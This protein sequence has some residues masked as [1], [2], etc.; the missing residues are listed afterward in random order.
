MMP[1]RIGVASL[2]PSRGEASEMR[3]SRSRSVPFLLGSVVCAAMLA[4]PGSGQRI[5]AQDRPCTLETEPNDQLAS[6]P[7][8]AGPLCV[9]GELPDGDQDLVVWEVRPVDTLV[10]WSFGVSGVPRT[11][12]SIHVFPVTSPPGVALDTGG[13]MMRIDS[14]A[15]DP[16][17]G[18][19]TDIALPAGRYVLGISRGFPVGSR[20]PTDLGYRVWVEPSVAPPPVFDPEP[21]DDA[22]TGG[23]VARAFALSGDLAGSDDHVRW[24]LSEADAG[25]QWRLDARVPPGGPL[26][27]TVSGPG[28]ELLADAAAMPDGRARISDLQLPAGTYD[29]RLSAG[30]IEG[31]PYL[32][33]AS[34]VH[35]PFADTEPNDVAARAVPLDPD[36]TSARGRLAD[37][38]DRDTFR[39]SVDATRAAAAQDVVLVATGGRSHQVCLGGVVSQCRS[40]TDEVRLSN[41]VLVPGELLIEVSGDVDPEAGYELTLRSAGAPGPGRE[42]EP[43]DDPASAA[44][45][46]PGVVLAGR[47]DA[48]DHDH[49]LAV[50]EGETL[51]WRLEADGAAIK[52]LDWIQRDGQPL[53][54]GDISADETHAVL[55]DLLLDPGRHWFAVRASEGDYALRLIPMGPPDPDGE[56]EPNDDTTRAQALAIDHPRTGR[57][58][59]RRD[60]DVYRFSLAAREHV[61]MEL[62]PPQDGGVA[63]ELRSD[64]TTLV[65][66]TDTEPGVPVRHDLWL[67]AGDYEVWLRPDPVSES[68]HTLSLT[69]QDPF[70]PVA[71][72]P[73]PIAPIALSLSTDTPEV[74]AY[75]P[76]GQHVV[77]SLDI[78]DPGRSPAASPVSLTL[79]AL[80]SHHAWAATLDP[81]I[82]EVPAGG[83]TRVL[84][85]I[86]VQPDVAADLP[87]RITVRARDAIGGQWTTF[88]DL[89]PRARARVIDP[90]PAWHV[91]PGLLGGLD[92]AAQALG[93]TTTGASD[94]ISAALLHD[95]YAVSGSGLV[96]ASGGQPITHVVDLAG[97]GP[98]EIAGFLLDPVAGEGVLAE[99]PRDFEV[100]LSLDGD[101]WTPVVSAE[102]SPLRREQ[103]FVLASPMPARFARLV[104]T[105]THGAPMGRVAL[106]EWK[107]VATPG[108]VADATPFDLAD[109]A[110]GGHVVRMAPLSPDP[111]TAEG[112]LSAD[113]TA[114]RPNLGG[115]TA[116]EWVVGFAEDRAAQV[117][118]VAWLDPAGSD[119]AQQMTAITVES[120][121]D[122]PLGPWQPLGAGTLGR[123]ADGTMAPLLLD[124]PTWARFVRFTGHPPASGSA[125]WELPGALQIRERATDTTYRSI[126]GQW[127]ATSRDGIHE[128]LVPPDVAVV[129]AVDGDDDTPADATPL[130]PGVRAVD[131]VEIDRDLDWYVLTVPTDRNQLTLELGGAPTVGASITMQ[132][133]AGADVPLE[134]AL[135]PTATRATA[136]VEPGATYHV[137]VEQEPVSVVFSYDTSGSMARFLPFVAA[138]LRT[139]AGD[140]TPGHE[141][142]RIIPLQE[143]PLLPD[144]SDD[145]ASLRDAVAGAVVPGG[146]SAVEAGLVEATASF[147]HRPGRHALLVIT[148]AESSSSDRTVDLWQHLEST[149]PLVFSL[150]IGG[151]G[152]PRVSSH[153]MQDWA[154][155]TGG[156]YQYASSHDEVD[157]A[158]ERMA[159]WLRRPA[160]YTLAFEATQVVLEPGR[161]SVSVVPGSGAN[162]VAGTD[163]AVEVILDTSGSMLKRLGSRSRISVAKDVLRDLVTETLPAGAPVAVRIFGTRSKVCGTRLAVPLGPLDPVAVST[164]LD[165]ITAVQEADTPIGQA[166]TAVARDL[167]SIS[168]ARIVVLITDSEEVWPHR[169]LCRSDP[170]KAIRGLAAA[171]IDIRLNIV[172]FA[173]SDRTAK[174]QM[175]EWAHLG[176]GS[177]FDAGDEQELAAGIARAL[178]A[179]IDVYDRH[180]VVVGVGT[181]GGG[182]IDVPVG[183][184]RVEVRSDPPVTFQDVVVTAGMGVDLT[185]GAEG[186][187]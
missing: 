18:M 181:V 16:M 49:Y 123:V 104:I 125:T 129:P 85:D 173:L 3:G 34:P 35:A 55:R 167:S 73:P 37:P 153:L 72:A 28:G 63:L 48:A 60:V 86:V 148:D 103:A 141:A 53:A 71:D 45:L 152:A 187:P 93:A 23:A 15:D 40:G 158:F 177:F 157:R 58:A 184:Y 163:V 121:L 105:S 109:P 13:E 74:A 51:V 82:V 112:L 138:A 11:I 165:R 10:S 80:T 136:I 61:L 24:T 126:L 99:V 68:D 128:L 39:L 164:L 87:V 116:L 5:A 100:A 52:R 41:L 79:D 134:R 89:V 44:P 14:S 142:V 147:T 182:P 114:W 59:M 32:L 144:W 76:S 115:A 159:T 65:A 8:M 66:A 54:V 179:P 156:R 19:A 137:R 110:L 91:P 47:G 67:E 75:A 94:P 62:V 64:G 171:E 143:A 146:S 4:V 25:G 57:L 132:D 135:A 186:E 175:R 118:R 88:L 20:A 176:N 43:N 170:R 98:I 83:T 124:E 127:G 81:V 174:A 140:V 42:V 166:I 30:T 6:A 26:Q 145:A 56:Q 155:A 122:S 36:T 108:V 12:T 133:S 31:L 131:Q 21:N 111:A 77:A 183:R 70:Q 160:D 180:G 46:A 9:T 117:D 119:P 2:T 78:G 106:G 169:D 1:A 120:S 38:G 107:V 172:G 69:R 168:G 17:P 50:T 101:T 161:I 22:A 96:V 29:L 150:H 92:V 113:L 102:L 33:A 90:V 139:F 97:E 95:G 130:E 7:S 154:A 149:R 162:V 185:L 151:S 27:L 178:A 84:V